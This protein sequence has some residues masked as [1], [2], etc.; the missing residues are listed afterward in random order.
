MEPTAER[1]QHPTPEELRRFLAGTAT[2][3]ERKR[4]AVHLLRGCQSCAL[5]LRGILRPEPSPEGAYDEVLLR[6]ARQQGQI[7]IV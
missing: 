7:P 1:Q 6:F 3:E 2:Q 4:V 5:I